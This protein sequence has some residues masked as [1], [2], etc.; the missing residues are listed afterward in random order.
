MAEIGDTGPFRFLGI[1]HLHGLEVHDSME[2]FS[3]SLQYSSK[4]KRVADT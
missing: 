1:F 4:A 3:L 2:I